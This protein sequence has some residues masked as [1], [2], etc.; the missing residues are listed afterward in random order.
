[1]IKNTFRVI[2]NRSG[3]GKIQSVIGDGWLVGA[4]HGLHFGSSGA[5]AD[6]SPKS[7]RRWEGNL[8]SKKFAPG[9]NPGI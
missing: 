5:A 1:M 6:F 7:I 9:F 4:D 8:H 2:T 3:N